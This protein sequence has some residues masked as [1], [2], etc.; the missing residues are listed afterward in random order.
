MVEVDRGEKAVVGRE[1]VE[2][3]AEG[4]RTKRRRRRKRTRVDGW[5]GGRKAV[6]GTEGGSGRPYSA[7][8]LLSKSHSSEA[9]GRA[10]PRGRGGTRCTVPKKVQHREVY[11]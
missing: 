5:V 7:L 10:D 4:R 11:R 8:S 3:G 6:E 1:G 2:S 9:D